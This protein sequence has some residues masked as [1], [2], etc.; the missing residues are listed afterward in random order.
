MCCIC[1]THASLGLHALIQSLI[2]PPPWVRSTAFFL[3]NSKLVR[4]DETDQERDLR[5]RRVV[6]EWQKEG[7]TLN[8]GAWRSRCRT[9]FLIRSGI[10]VYGSTGGKLGNS[11]DAQRLIYLARSQGKE[12][13]CIEAVYK[14]IASMSMLESSLR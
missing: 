9:L 4:P 10:A 3:A 11:F 6:T 13:A 1:R 5:R 14:A 2:S 7:L 8:D 12:D